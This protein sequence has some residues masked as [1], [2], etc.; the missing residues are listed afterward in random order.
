MQDVSVAEADSLR[1]SSVLTIIDIRSPGEYRRDRLPGA[2]NVPADRLEA[3]TLPENQVLYYCKT[4]MRTN[5]NRDRLVAKS[6]GK[7]YILKG[8]LDAWAGQGLPVERDAKAP[9][10]IERQIQIVIGLMLLGFTALSVLVSPS[11]II[12]P[13]LIGAGLLM[14]GLTGFCGLGLVV[15]KMPWNRS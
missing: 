3:E 14:A 13:G 4:G 9:L 1:N 11:F 12:V 7:G 10:P 8:G 15:A 5:L 6:N 2:I